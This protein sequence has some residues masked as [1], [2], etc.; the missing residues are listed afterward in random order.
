MSWS[1][2]PA[3]AFSFFYWLVSFCFIASPTEFQSAGFTIQSLFSNLLGSEML[4]FVD[5]HIRRTSTTVIFHASI[6]LG[7]F[8]GMT[9]V[10]ESG[11]DFLEISEW[12]IHTGWQ[13]YF[14]VA[15]GIFLGATTLV[16]YWYMNGWTNHPIVQN[17]SLY[18]QQWKELAMAVNAEFRSIDKYTSSPSS[19]SSLIVTDNWIIK[20]GPYNVVFVHQDFVRLSVGKTEEYHVSPNS[21]TTV[22]YVRIN[23]QPTKKHKPFGIR[24]MSTDYTEFKAK[25]KVEVH[26]DPSLTIHRTSSELFLEAF[27][28][29]VL[30]NPLHIVDRM[31]QYGN[32]IGCDQKPASVKLIKQ[33]ADEN[34]GDCENCNCN[35]LWCLECMGRWYASRQDQSSPETWLGSFATCP[36]CRA[37][38]CMLDVSII[39]QT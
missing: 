23:V 33:C 9:F 22:Q 1:I 27:K 35:P 10:G 21:L 30:K 16:F 11:L 4:N 15:V 2:S 6:P 26:A 24:I 34:E 39:Q 7:Y 13:I 31:E 5:Y 3:I 32:C 28:D 17:L 19:S 8:I 14:Y 18:S 12:A 38:F 37:H 29:Q 25:L 36:M 20:S